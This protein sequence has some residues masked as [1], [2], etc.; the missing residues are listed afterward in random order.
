VTLGNRYLERPLEAPVLGKAVNIGAGAKILGK[1]MIGDGAQIGANAVVL[2]DVPAQALAVGI[3]A[4][5]VQR[6]ATVSQAES[7]S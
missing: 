2:T 1:V 3:P 5:I 7:R 4:R 6:S